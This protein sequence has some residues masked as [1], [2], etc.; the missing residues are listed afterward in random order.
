MQVNLVSGTNN[1]SSNSGGQLSSAI[2]LSDP[3]VR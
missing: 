1:T 3:Q 2:S